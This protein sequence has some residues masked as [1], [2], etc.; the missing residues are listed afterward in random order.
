LL[1]Q[2][3]NHGLGHFYENLA[4]LSNA[5]NYLRNHAQ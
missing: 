1:C 4:S 2:N 5:I 3:C